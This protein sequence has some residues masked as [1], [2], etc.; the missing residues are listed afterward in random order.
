M[1]D[2][3]CKGTICSSQFS[4]V[5][6]FPRAFMVGHGHVWSLIVDSSYCK[7]SVIIRPGIPSGIKPQSIT[8]IFLQK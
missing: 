2:D 3:Y 4:S 7:R 5:S 8:N 6:N 1:S